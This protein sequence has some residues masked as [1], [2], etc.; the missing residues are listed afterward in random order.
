MVFLEVG[1]F[2]RGER[3]KDIF[4]TITFNKAGLY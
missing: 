4:R 2:L 1:L 3:F